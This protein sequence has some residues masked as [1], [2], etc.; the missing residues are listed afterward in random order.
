MATYS[1][2]QKKKTVHVAVLGQDDRELIAA[3]RV[4][5]LD[6]IHVLDDS[7]CL[8]PLAPKLAVVSITKRPYFVVTC[9]DERVRVAESARDR[10]GCFRRRCPVK[11]ADHFW[12]TEIVVAGVTGPVVRAIA[13]RVP[14]TQNINAMGFQLCHTGFETCFSRAPNVRSETHRN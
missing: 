2:H 12:G 7:G 14:A 11:V 5:E 3:L 8:A 6:R 13:P 10:E 4:N 1:D 9:Y